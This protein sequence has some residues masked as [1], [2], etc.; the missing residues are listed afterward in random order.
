MTDAQESMVKAKLEEIAAD[1][2]AFRGAIVAISTGNAGE[3]G[4]VTV[5]KSAG[6]KEMVNLFTNIAAQVAIALAAETTPGKA[7]ELFRRYGSDAKLVLAYGFLTT[8]RAA[9]SKDIAGTMRK[10]LDKELE[11]VI[12]GGNKVS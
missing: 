3:E 11:E 4:D 12:G 2:P 6:G 8:V 10:Q 9:L 7:V 5:F 1:I